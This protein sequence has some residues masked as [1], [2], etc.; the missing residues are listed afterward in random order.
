M[1]EGGG[2]GQRVIASL[3]SQVSIERAGEPGREVTLDGTGCQRAEIGIGLDRGRDLVPQAGALAGCL[4]P[5]RHHVAGRRRDP[6]RAAARQGL[7][8]Q[9]GKV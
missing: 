4:R 1:S 2:Q 8:P 7:Y 9:R 5:H 3:N 6:Q